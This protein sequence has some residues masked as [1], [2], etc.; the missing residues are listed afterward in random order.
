MTMVM[1]Y[2]YVVAT[3]KS[4]YQLFLFIIWT[5]AFW[6]NNDY[7]YVC[8]IMY[9]SLCGEDDEGDRRGEDKHCSR[10]REDKQLR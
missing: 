6:N 5:N 2:M 1:V 9:L 7:L 10:I 4:Q 3:R 8:A